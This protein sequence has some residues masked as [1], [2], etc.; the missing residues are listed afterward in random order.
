MSDLLNRRFPSRRL[1]RANRY[2]TGAVATA[3]NETDFKVRTQSEGSVE[4]GRYR[5]RTVP[6]YISCAAIRLVSALLLLLT[7]AV[8]IATAKSLSEYHLQLRE[9]ITALDTMS[10]H[11]ESESETDRTSRV[12]KTIAGVRAALP[13]TDSVQV[14]ANT[15]AVN[16][17]WLHH[18]LDTYEKTQTDRSATLTRILERLRALEQRVAEFDREGRTAVDKA[19]TS[20]RLAEIL[21][22]PEYSRNAQGES[23]LVRLWNE[24][25]KWLQGLIPKP[26]PLTPGSAGWI[27]QIAQVLIVLLA[28][29]VIFYV[30]KTFAP[31]VF[32]GRRSK[33]KVKVGPRIVLGE[34]LAAD[35]SASDILASAEA[36]ARRGELRA[37]IRKAYIALLVELG[38]R[39][40][41][42]L[43]QHKTNRDYLRAMREVEPLHTNVKQLTDSFE[44]HWYGFALATDSDWTTFRA[45]YKQALQGLN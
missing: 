25:M 8:T 13:Q 10:Q 5:S 7:F 27:S 3:F 23:A 20:K 16:N 44:R 28:L 45:R 24:L 37:A 18:E 40:I 12:N 22:R 17:A 32:K 36:L 15:V 14:G 29:A 4:C 9:A 39:K 42:S 33:K 2:S 43:A 35:E 41:L 19:G 11:D 30:L 1:D 6:A 34:T 31:R 38:E 26:R 21:Q